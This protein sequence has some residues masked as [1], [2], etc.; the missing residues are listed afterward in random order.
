MKNIE[1]TITTA[2]R[3]AFE[4]HPARES[5]P[6]LALQSARETAAELIPPGVRGEFDDEYMCFAVCPDHTPA[7]CRGS[8]DGCSCGAPGCVEYPLVP[9]PEMTR[10]WVDAE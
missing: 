3:E 9:S 7:E 8:D 6:A 2:F 4:S 10:D 5:D 1:N